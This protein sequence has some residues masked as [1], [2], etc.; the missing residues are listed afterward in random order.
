MVQAKVLETVSAMRET[1]GFFEMENIWEIKTQA[2][3]LNL[4]ERKTLRLTPVA[5]IRSKKL[6][7]K[8]ISRFPQLDKLHKASF[9]VSR[10]LVPPSIRPNHR[11]LLFTYSISLEIVYLQLFFS[12]PLRYK[13]ILRASCQFPNPS[14]SFSRN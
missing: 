8:L 10:P 14:L 6:D 9:C 4:R 11:G 5:F 7:E 13:I 1:W 3:G 2:L 12:T